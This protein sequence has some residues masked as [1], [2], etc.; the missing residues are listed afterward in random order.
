[1]LGQ[2][3]KKKIR[4]VGSLSSAVIA[5]VA[6]GFVSSVVTTRILGP[7]DYGDMKFIQNFFQFLA[8]VFAIGVFPS[9]ALLLTK[10]G[11]DDTGKKEMIGALLAITLILSFITVI[12]TICFS[13]FENRIFNNSL[14]QLIFFSAPL[15]AI[16]LFQPCL[17]YILQGDNQIYKLSVFRILPGL[18]YIFFMVGLN[19]IF[20]VTLT[21]ALMIQ[22]LTGSVVTIAI[23]HI[24]HPKY[25]NFARNK[26]LI[27]ESNKQYGRHVYTGSLSSVAT[28][29]LAT[30]M[31]S[32]FLDNKQVGFFSLAVTLTLPLM[33]IPKAVG[34]TYFKDF[35]NTDF[36]PKK[37]TIVSVGVTAVILLIFLVIIKPLVL[38]VYTDQFADVA[39]LSIMTA[40]GSA[41]FGV[42]D[43][44]NRFLGAHGKGKEL[45]N[46]AFIV[47]AVNVTG[48]SILVLLMGVIGAAVTQFLAG[49]VYLLTMTLYYKRYRS[50]K[51]HPDRTIAK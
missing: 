28:S 34:T 21:T 16:F 10:M 37:V 31:I 12:V 8:I 7:E 49:A 2:V 27:F 18:L 44:I 50:E 47:G 17:E 23:I 36:L 39:T 9:G 48:Y 42:G 46:G 41:S 35:A 20:D 30:F 11:A 33:Q 43:Y 24:L 40:F 45:R 32:Y 51:L 5:S 22:I 26:A 15:A 4:Q 38:L 6:I 25:S 14:G 1:M 19:F 3:S 29:Y 13:F